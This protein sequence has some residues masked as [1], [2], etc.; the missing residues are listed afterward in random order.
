VGASAIQRCISRSRRGLAAL[1]Q[2]SD[3][4]RLLTVP[5]QQWPKRDIVVDKDGI[6]CTDDQLIRSEYA[7]CTVSV[8]NPGQT[9]V[10][11]RVFTEKRPYADGDTEFV[12][13]LLPGATR[14]IQLRLSFSSERESLFV[15]TELNVR[16]PYVRTS[17]D[18]ELTLQPQNAAA[19]LHGLAEPPSDDMLPRDDILMVR[20]SFTAPVRTFDVQ[21]MGV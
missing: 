3:L 5:Q 21:W 13:R 19:V 2:L 12:V 20:G 17:K 10:Y 7:A 15:G 11:A 6:R 14:T 16:T 4:P 9:T 1:E 18:G 8:S